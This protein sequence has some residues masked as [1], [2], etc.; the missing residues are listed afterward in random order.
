MLV[1]PCFSSGNVVLFV[2]SLP[3]RLASVVAFAPV[4]L[5]YAASVPDSF[6]LNNSNAYL[7][8]C[9]CSKKT[10]LMKASYSW[11]YPSIR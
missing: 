10:N 3:W 4:V 1:M 8:L 7:L 6:V 9:V 2:N 11:E 5:R